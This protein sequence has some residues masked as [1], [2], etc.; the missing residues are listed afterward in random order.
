MTQRKERVPLFGSWGKA[1][2]AIVV[3]F[4]FEVALFYLVS[5]Y[6]S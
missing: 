4:A 6:F 2:F 1:Y 3:I 5:H